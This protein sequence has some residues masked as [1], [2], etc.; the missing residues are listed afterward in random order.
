MKKHIT[1]L[2]AALFIISCSPAM[3]QQFTI[4]DIP[5]T[6]KDF[7]VKEGFRNHPYSAKIYTQ[8]L[9]WRYELKN[10][11]IKFDLE[12]VV[13]RDK[14]WVKKEFMDKAGKEVKQQLLDHEKGHL[15][16]AMINLQQ[17]G[18]ALNNFK[19]TRNYKR[20][21]DSISKALINQ[22][23]LTNETYD[24]QTNHMLITEKQE[25]WNNKLLNQLNGLYQGQKL[26]MKF[27]VDI[28]I[29]S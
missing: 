12:L 7:I 5:L 1:S 25:E 16:I 8:I 9:P 29:N 15:V 26:R 19:Y 21:I 11:K 17:M 20:E 2:W 28:D 27:E 4:E 18:N 3:A 23:T 14:S 6:W 24:T 13:D 10:G 22:L